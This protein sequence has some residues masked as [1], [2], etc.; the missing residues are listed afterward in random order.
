MEVNINKA[1]NCRSCHVMVFGGTVPPPHISG[2]ALYSIFSAVNTVIGL[3][4][5]TKSVD[6]WRNLCVFI[7]YCIAHVRCRRKESS[8]SL[9]H[10]L[11]SFL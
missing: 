3:C 8:H 9:S 2:P 4:L 5:A 6:L 10:L 7:V 11:M 1:N